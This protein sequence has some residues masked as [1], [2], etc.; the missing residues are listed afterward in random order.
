MFSS[1]TKLNFINILQITLKIQRVRSFHQRWLEVACL[2]SYSWSSLVWGYA[3]WLDS[4]SSQKIKRAPGNVST[5]SSRLSQFMSHRHIIIIYFLQWNDAISRNL[6][7]LCLIFICFFSGGSLLYEISSLIFGW[8]ETVWWFVAW[9]CCM[10][11]YIYTVC[12]V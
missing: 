1:D 10:C 12:V 8:L 9:H 11:I 6:T 7:V 2:L 4:S 5:R 3:Q